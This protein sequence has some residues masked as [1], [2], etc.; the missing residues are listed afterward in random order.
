MISENEEGAVGKKQ[1]IAVIGLGYV[2]LPL[3]LSMVNKG[4]HVVG[5]DLDHRKIELLQ[6]GC[7]YIPDIKDFVI[8]SAVASH[9]FTTTGEY[10]AIE[11]A[12]TIII[13]VP[14]PLTVYHTPDLSYLT[15]AGKAISY[16]IKT[17]QLVILESSTYPGTTKEV[18][19]PILEESMLK[20]GND[21]FLGFS[22]ERIDP[23]NKHYT[24]D[25]IPKV[26]SGITQECVRRV[27]D[28][29]S[30]IFD[31]VVA[32]SSTE[33]AELTKLL[34]NSYRFINISFIN[35][36][37]MLCDAMNINV[38]EVIE[39]ASSKPYGY[40]AFYPGPGVGGHCIP[41]DPLYL[42]WKAKQFGF[43]SRFIELSN[44]VN[45][46]IP[47]Y[48]VQQIKS[49]LAPF[50]TLRDSNILIYGVAYKRNIS[51]V[52]ESSALQLMEL[53]LFEGVHLSYH[54]PFVPSVWIG[55]HQMNSV[56]MTDEIL[57]NNDCV[58]IATDHSC[59]P[60]L[61]IIEHSSLVFDTRNATQG[62][63]GKAKVYRLGGGR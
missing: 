24:I 13:C 31:N 47:T 16:R 63:K 41:V 18:L 33:T 1:T 56:E 10:D 55:G 54:D 27:H 3:A 40:S 39:A 61:Q 14:T 29:Y 42:Q 60:L 45:H 20:V 44:E 21:I 35:E 46:R 12:D 38:W 23:G 15:K 49:L 43:D 52:R 32:V 19:Q 11:C 28:L 36:F 59:I 57:Q 8:Q 26:I 53:L 25:T 5:I 17:G 58:V 50:K 30:Q 6:K 22:P 48:I 2:G 34:E 37:A 7:S 9:R 62:M 4:F 51:D